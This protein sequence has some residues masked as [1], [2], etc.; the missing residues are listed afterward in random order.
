MRVE[1]DFE[2]GRPIMVTITN[3]IPIYIYL[4]ISGLTF[5]IKMGL[6]E[7]FILGN[8]IIILKLDD[9]WLHCQFCQIGV[10]LGSI[11][12]NNYLHKVL[13]TR[14]GLHWCCNWCSKW[15]SKWCCRWCDLQVGAQVAEFH[16]NK[17]MFTIIC[18]ISTIERIWIYGA[19]HFYTNFSL[20]TSLVKKYLH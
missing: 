12:C 14:I 3:C 8:V 16:Q 5:S 18:W 9:W 10:I 17:M 19:M 7:Y 11:K 20:R 1:K 6:I 15:C 4:F 13:K 2:V